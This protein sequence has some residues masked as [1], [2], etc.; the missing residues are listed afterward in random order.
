MMNSSFSDSVRAVQQAA[1]AIRENVARVSH[2]EA[3]RD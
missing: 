2:W 3:G 1:N